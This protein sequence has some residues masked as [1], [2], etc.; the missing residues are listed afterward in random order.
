VDAGDASPVH[1]GLRWYELRRLPGGDWTIHQQ[2]THAPDADHR[3]LGSAAMDGAGN[4]ALAYNVSGP[5]LFPSIRYAGRLATD[6]PNRLSLRENTLR[7]GQAPQGVIPNTSAC[8]VSNGTTFCPEFADYTQ[9]NVDPV[10]DCTLWFVSQYY[11][12]SFPP[13]APFAPWSTHIGAFRFPTCQAPPLLSPT[14][15]AT[16]SPTAS[17]TATATSTATATAT[18]TAAA[19]V[20]AT[21]TG[22]PPT[23]TATPTPTG[24]LTTVTAVGTATAT[25]TATA[26]P[27][28]PTAAPRTPTATATPTTGVGTVFRVLVLAVSATTGTVTLGPLTP[29]PCPRPIANCLEFDVS[30][31]FTVTGTIQGLP[32]GAVPILTIPVADAAG[33][34]AGTRP[35]TCSAADARGV[36]T[37]NAGVRDPGLVPRSGATIVVEAP[38]ATPLVVG[39]VRPPPLLPPLPPPPPPAPLVPPAPPALAA[40]PAF[41]EVPVIPETESAALLGL[42]LAVLGLQAM[43]RARRHRRRP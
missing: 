43:W 16:P 15:T 24:T 7:H 34:P 3:W 8:F 27:A 41:P 30:G 4:L 31:S 14:P 40:P 29:G 23:G 38:P 19:S 33:Q 9:L 39:P 35:V 13:M 25:R 12:T 21:A 2:A 20:T 36:S 6:P 5:G 18:P 22:A 1:V 37:C 28:P 11:P 26:T 42:G 10:D 32:P 17:A